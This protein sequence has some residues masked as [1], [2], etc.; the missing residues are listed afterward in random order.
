MPAVDN[1]LTEK[2]LVLI[3]P[4][5]V[6]SLK[7]GSANN[8]ASAAWGSYILSLRD[9]AEIINWPCTLSSSQSC[10]Q[11]VLILPGGEFKCPKENGFECY[12]QAESKYK[13]YLSFENAMC[14]DYVTE[15][16]FTVYSLN[17]IPGGWPML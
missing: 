15:K 13:F 1:S 5:S 12:R 10:Q 7:N 4:P 6:C 17:M 14:R 3:C 11:C 16:F 2:K 9:L 8:R